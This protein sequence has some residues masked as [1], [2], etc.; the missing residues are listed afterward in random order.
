[1]CQYGWWCPDLWLGGFETF[2]LLPFGNTAA[3]QFERLFEVVGLVQRLGKQSLAEI[4]EISLFR[5]AE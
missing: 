3:R 2:P 4:G 1:M 5:A